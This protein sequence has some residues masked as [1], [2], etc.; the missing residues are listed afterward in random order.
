MRI[1]IESDTLKT[2]EQ[3]LKY[4]SKNFIKKLIEYGHNVY[5]RGN[6]SQWIEKHF[7]QCR[8]EFTNEN[9]L[10]TKINAKA[11]TKEKKIILF[12]SER[13]PNFESI[14]STVC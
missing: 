1:I 13:Y 10:I 2:S 3:I 9:I 7:P 6:D 12:G 14:I 11:N 4:N 8:T 5:I